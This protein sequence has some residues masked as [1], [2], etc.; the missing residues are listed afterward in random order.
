MI[1]NK[2][3]AYLDLNEIKYVTVQHSA[4]YTAQEIAASAH[5]PGRELAKTVVVRIDDK[6]AMVV[7][8]ASNRVSPVALERVVGSSN[9]R[10][11]Q[12]HEFASRFPDCEL[13]AMPPFGNLYDMEVYVDPDLS[14]D[15][16][17]AFNAGSHTDLIVM[18]Y[19]DFERVV[20]PKVLVP[21]V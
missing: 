15:E 1:A 9:V 12:E 8:P 21:M 16:M 13:G 14:K 18:R 6:L 7:I 11:A 19:A 10:L 2:I 5:I 17:I 3:R 20:Q 4:A